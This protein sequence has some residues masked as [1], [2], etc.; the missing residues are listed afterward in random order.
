MSKISFTYK[1]D[2]HFREALFDDVEMRLYDVVELQLF[3][4]D[5][6]PVLTPNCTGTIYY[7][8]QRTG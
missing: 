8:M 5:T 7:C 2:D 3:F 6:N 4:T 1:K